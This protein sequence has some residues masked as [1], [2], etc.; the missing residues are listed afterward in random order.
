MYEEL[1]KASLTLRRDLE[2]L[3]A[4]GA[5]PRLHPNGFIQVDLTVDTRVHVW[6]KEELPRADP[7][8]PIHDHT[9]G[10]SSLVVAGSVRNI[11]LEPVVHEGGGYRLWEIK[12][13]AD[14]RRTP[15][16][17]FIDDER[18][19]FRHPSDRRLFAG[20]MY[21]MRP[22]VFHYSDAESGTV[23]II[24]IHP[25]A[26]GRTAR[27]AAPLGTEPDSRFERDVTPE[28]QAELWDMIFRTIP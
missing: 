15:M 28:R 6:P 21:E 19:A 23:T 9:Y 24:R 7:Y 17:V 26:P 14:E 1:K 4:A 12:Q 18:Y 5:A 11:D 3:R 25:S 27:I 20:S 16:P 22:F 10:F 13:W 2:L 8:C